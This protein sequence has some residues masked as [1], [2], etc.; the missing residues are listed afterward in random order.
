MFI[1][2]A[3]IADLMI[4]L[5]RTPD[6]GPRSISA[7]ILN[8]PT[9]GLTVDAPL[10]KLGWR[11]SETNSVFFE[12]CEIGDDAMLGSAGSGF[13]LVMKGFNLERAVLAAGSVGL[14]Q[15]ALDGAIKYAKDRTQFG[16][17]LAS[18]Q[19]VRH[20]ISR[21]A[22]DIES[23]RQL[24]YHVARLIEVGEEGIAAASM[25]KL[26]ASEMCQTVAR[27]C[28]Q[29]HGGAG[30]MKEYRAERYYRDS[31]IMTI[32]GGTSEIQA[33]IIGRHLTL[34]DRITEKRNR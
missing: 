33:E 10:D 14:A 20:T 31:M 8:M 25:A 16:G 27:R 1:T 18:F 34:T 9:K 11:A 30:F 4:V 24:T 23:A 22:A 26:V 5:A 7:F 6:E 28:I 13:S 29:I 19:A 21:S 17:T 2:N 3:G 12:E 32:G 15:G